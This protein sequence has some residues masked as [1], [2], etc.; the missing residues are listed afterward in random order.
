[1]ANNYNTNPYLAGNYGFYPNYNVYPPSQSTA[2]P[3]YQPSGFNVGWVNSEEDGRNTYVA[4]GTSAY[5]MDKNNPVMYLKSVDASGHVSEF[6]AFD[7]VEH[8]Q[9]QMDADKPQITTESISE[10][11]RKT[12]AEAGWKFKKVREEE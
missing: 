5:F 6:K 7:L 11:V 2:M 10:I 12:M 9:V 4:P 1:M 8:K 3:N